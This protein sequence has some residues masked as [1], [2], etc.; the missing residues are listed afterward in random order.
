MLKFHDMKNKVAFI[1]AS[2]LILS[3]CGPTTNEVVKFNDAIVDIINAIDE[4]HTTLLNFFD[5]EDITESKLKM[6]LNNYRDFLKEKKKEVENLKCPDDEKVKAFK[7]AALN[8]IDEFIKLTEN[9]YVEV[10]NLIFSSEKD[11]TTEQYFDSL[12]DKIDNTEK[13]YYDEVKRAQKEMADKFNIT[14]K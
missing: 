6:E 8:M 14:L 7:N 9:E 12:L 13:K 1:L 3:G 11:D 10:I 2:I 5:E 4:K